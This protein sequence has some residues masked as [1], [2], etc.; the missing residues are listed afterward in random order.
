MK[1]L[2]RPKSPVSGFTIVELLIV[3]V[4][5][6]I[7]AAITIVAYNGIQNRANDSAIQNDLKNIAKQ[8]ELHKVDKGVYPVGD[9][10]LGSSTLSLKTSHSS[11]GNGMINNRYNLLY[12][13]VT[14]SGPDAFALIASSKSGTVFTYR[15]ATGAIT[16]TSAWVSLDNSQPNCQAVGINQTIS[17]D[18]DFFFIDSWRPYAR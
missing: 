7:L 2:S 10:Q 3:I 13:R 18:R 5:I 16:Q 6:A 8:F 9:E 4:V 11:Y 14:A 1:Q 17:T 15:S 12:C